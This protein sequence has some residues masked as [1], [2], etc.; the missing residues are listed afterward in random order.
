M[1]TNRIL[2]KL[3][4]N[5]PVPVPVVWTVPHWKIVE[6]IG[7]AGY[8]CVW[9]EMEHSDY[10]L[11]NMSQMILAARATGMEAIVRV[12]RRGYTDY[13]KTLEAGATG[14]I[15]PHCTNA[16]EAREF[17]RATRFQP[18]GWRGMG[19][20]VDT[21]YGTMPLDKYWEHGNN[22]VLLAVMIERKE[23]V[24]DID[25]IVAVEGLDGVVIGPGD[26]SQSYG[27][28]GQFDH[29]QIHEARA[30]VAEACAKHGKW[31]GCPCQSPEAAKTLMPEGARFLFAWTTELGALTT[32]FSESMQA[33]TELDLTA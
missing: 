20:S 12:P 3:R 21:Q 17:V 25:A 7:L 33:F 11:E 5:E 29:P 1:K 15:Y 6:M 16:D 19:G 8:E 14:L 23:A 2:A 26:L 24:D 9:I 4:A 30:R 18:L 10:T 32:A 28:I 13:I 22:E 27:L 31:W